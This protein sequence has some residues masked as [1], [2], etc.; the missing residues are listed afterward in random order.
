MSDNINGYPEFFAGGCMARLGL[1]RDWTCLFA[2]EIC[3]KKATAYR[4]NF[5]LGDELK[6]EGAE[7]AA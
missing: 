3:K 2:N 1:E 5:G 7:R 6:V 4:L